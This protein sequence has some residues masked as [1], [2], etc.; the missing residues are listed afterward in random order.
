VW[1]TP[2]AREGHE[3]AKNFEFVIRLNRRTRARVTVRWATKN[4]TAHA[5]S[6]YVADSGVVTFPDGQP[7]GRYERRVVIRVKGDRKAEPNESFELV[8][9]RPVNA[10]VGSGRHWAT[11]VNDDGP[12]RA[13]RR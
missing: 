12:V 5:P 13:S 8:L 1:S 11:I 2:N 7:P 3:G 6:D 9:S 4:G 10:R